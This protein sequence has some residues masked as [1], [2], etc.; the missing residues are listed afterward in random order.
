MS[1]SIKERGRALEG[2]FFA[3]RER[4][5]LNRIRAR[6]TQEQSIEELMELTG[7]RDRGV[8]R[9]V[10][11]QG[12][13]PESLAAFSVVPML[14]VAWG[15]GVLD[16][17]ERSTI[18]LEAVALGIEQDSAGFLLLSSWTLRNPSRD[19]VGAWT[20]FTKAL[21]PL[22]SD[23]AKAHMK[24]DV[25]HRARRVARSS[26]GVLGFGTVSKPEREVLADLEA[27]FA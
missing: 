6:Q 7:I 13:T 27:L 5:L 12:V 26:G 11:D 15:D 4:D 14:A 21:V 10:T 16:H 3:E 17:H 8:L 19:L 1:D 20:Q 23:E 22:L 2:L 18:M 25:L 9:S 24:V